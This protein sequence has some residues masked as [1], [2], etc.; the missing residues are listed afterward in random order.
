MK[1]D[2]KINLQIEEING[3]YFI[4]G[5]VGKLDHFAQGNTREEAIFSF[6]KSLTWTIEENIKE[7]N[8]FI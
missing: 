8:K 7:I 1:E 6:F 4:E 2:I 5:Y 3:K